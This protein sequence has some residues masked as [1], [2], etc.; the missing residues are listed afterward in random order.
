MKALDTTF[1]LKR[2]YTLIELLGV[3]TII[4]ILVGIVYT[5]VLD[6]L[7]KARITAGIGLE[8]SIARAIP[9]NQVAF[10]SFDG[11]VDGATTCA[12]VNGNLL[13]FDGPGTA[14]IISSCPFGKC[15]KLQ[16]GAYMRL[17]TGQPR[18]YGFKP[19]T[20]RLLVM[21]W[22]K[23]D[24]QGSNDMTFVE[25]DTY[26]AESGGSSGDEIKTYLEADSG[27]TTRL[28][29][30]IP[31]NDNLYAC[32]SGSCSP[33]IDKRFWHH[34]VISYVGD[35][36]SNTGWVK[37]FLD[38]RQIQARKTSQY[39]TFGQLYHD[40]IMGNTNTGDVIYLDNIRIYNTSPDIGS[41]CSAAATY[42][43]FNN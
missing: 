43:D 2:G 26:G 36:A 21:A 17:A 23:V 37:Y 18:I 1:S 8:G 19:A 40:L 10:W 3:V 11:C 15:V 12:D 31:G 22:I 42:C 4:V 41:I 30:Y 9:E 29:T 16:N 24:A 28:K 13:A 33:T 20:G 39:Y 27:P 25:D 6:Y 14:N 7:E 35:Q 32:I 34:V 38:G 5:E